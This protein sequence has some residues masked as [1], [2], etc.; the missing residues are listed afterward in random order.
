MD[1]SS[2]Y[3]Y[4]LYMVIKICYSKDAAQRSVSSVAWKHQFSYDSDVKKGGARLVLDS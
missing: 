2:E 4:D 3:N 1:E